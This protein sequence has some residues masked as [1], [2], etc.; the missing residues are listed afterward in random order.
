MPQERQKSIHPECVYFT[1]TAGFLCVGTWILCRGYAV[2]MGAGGGE[3]RPNGSGLG[4]VGG[5]NGSAGGW[6][7]RRADKRGADWAGNEGRTVRQLGKMKA[8]GSAGGERRGGTDGRR[9]LF[10]K[11]LLDAEVELHAG[12]A[13]AREV[14]DDGLAVVRDDFALSELLVL[15]DGAG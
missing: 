5:P 2:G 13:A 4:R 15:D 10:Q 11:V 9:G 8:N 3:V 7:G 14:D 12:P 1:Q 6:P